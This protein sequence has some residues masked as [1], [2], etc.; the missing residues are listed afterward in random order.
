[1]F[2]TIHGFNSGYTHYGFEDRDLIQRLLDKGCDIRFCA[3]AV[4]L[5][6]NEDTLVELCKKLE[7]SAQYSAPLFMQQHPKAYAAMHY[8]K[9][10]AR[11]YPALRLMNLVGALLLPVLITMGE[12]GVHWPLPYSL[13]KWYVQ[14]VMMLSY[15]H[16]SAQ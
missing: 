12:R 1:V 7:A 2:E 5:H 13:K 14:G 10:D 11:L 6:A 4:A 16:G 15:L 8:A 3:S 9:V